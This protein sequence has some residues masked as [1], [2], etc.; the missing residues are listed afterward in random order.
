MANMN[1]TFEELESAAGQIDTGKDQLTGQLQ[2]LQSLAE[3]L[4]NSGFQTEQASRAYDSH[5][6]DYVTRTTQ[7][8]E[9]LT[10]YS[11]FL[12]TTA[13]TLRDTDSALAAQLNG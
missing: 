8:I 10:A 7:A 12:R 9:A 1:V 13:T 3:N 6:R 5:F 2:Q 11:T 4:I